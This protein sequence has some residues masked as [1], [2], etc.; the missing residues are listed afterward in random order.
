MST[1]DLEKIAYDVDEAVAAPPEEKKVDGLG[2]IAFVGP[3]NKAKAKQTK[4][5]GHITSAEDY[6]DALKKIGIDA[7]PTDWVVYFP[8]SKGILKTEDLRSID[9]ML[10]KLQEADWGK[11]LKFVADQLALRS[12]D[13]ADIADKVI[14]QGDNMDGS[15]ARQAQDIQQSINELVMRLEKELAGFSESE[16]EKVDEAKISMPQVIDQITCSLDEL[17]QAEDP[18]SS[19]DALRDIISAVAGGLL[20]LGEKKSAAT[21]SKIAMEIQPSEEPAVATSKESTSF[22]NI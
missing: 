20:K 21:L 14:W 2:M 9:E 17:A 5:Y 6:I 16:A 1:E 15:T 7:Q 12:K 10:A 19:V 18:H 3:K 4:N 11:S 8:E 13:L 22:T